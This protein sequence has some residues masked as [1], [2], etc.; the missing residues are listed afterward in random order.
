[1]EA[2]VS[3]D[4]TLVAV[5]VDGTVHMMLELTA[6]PAV[7]MA[8]AP[9]DAV[10]VLD[11]SGSMSGA[12]LHAVREATC[13]L[14]RL[15]GPDDRLGVVV[16]A[17]EATMVL[18]L[19]SHDP[20]V[21]SHQVRAIESGGSTNLSGGW[22]KGMEMLSGDVR[23]HALRRIIVLTD[24]HANVGITDSTALCGLMSA[25]RNQGITTSTIGFDDGYDEVLLAALADAGAGNDYWCAGPDQAPQVFAA[26]FDGLASVVAQNISVEIRPTK[27]IEMAVLNEYPIVAVDGGMQISLGDAYG[28]ERRRVVAMF[29]LNTPEAVGQV[30][31]G[32]LVVRWASTVGDVALR[33]TT[34]SVSVNTTDDPD[35]SDLVEN[36][37]VTDQVNV[38][39]AA[40]SRKEAHE[41]LMRDDIDGA[42]D[43]LRAAVETL[44][45]VDGD[46]VA[47]AQARFDLSELDRGAWSA[48]SSKRLFSTQRS[49]QK[50]RRSR[51]DESD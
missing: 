39:K 51:F 36:P 23:P 20:D 22:L 2:M 3:L 21:S 6:P 12:P 42:R 46:D 4:R 34:I 40:R 47:L 32:E 14:L 29:R 15:L 45:L 38:L 16:F 28:G 48:A 1:M 25:A 27:G 10:V 37:A 44:S 11:R 18:P 41:L 30:V 5:N 33:T 17:D 35:A 49:A 31:L 13:S 7:D 43:A 19:T 26:E 24:G 9:I 50:G 8:R